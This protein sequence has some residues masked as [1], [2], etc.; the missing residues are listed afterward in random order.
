MLGDSTN[1]LNH[2]PSDVESRLYQVGN[3]M[4]SLQRNQQD[5]ALSATDKNHLTKLLEIW[6]DDPVPEQNSFMSSALFEDA[7]KQ[8][9]R[10]LAEAL[11]SIMGQIAV[12]R[13]LWDKIYAKMIRSTAINLPA[14]A[15]ALGLVKTSPEGTNEVAKA[16]RV[17]LTS[18]DDETASNAVRGIYRWLAATSDLESKVPQPPEDLVLEVGIAIASRRNAV[19][20]AAMQLAE[21]IYGNGQD[22]HK[23]TIQQLV[24][25]GLTYLA[26]ELR[27]DHPHDN[28][29]EIPRKRFYCAKLAVAMGKCGLGE[30]PAVV[31]WL[32]M[33]KEDPLP[34]VRQA[35]AENDPHQ[36][37]RNRPQI[38]PD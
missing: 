16:L 12:S 38:E 21:W 18:D 3:A 10:E 29:D 33:A 31:T 15:L 32:E 11:T 25:H 30:S 28:S 6:A 35:I 37:W 26:Q 23:E 36:S 22:S 7:T 2:D 17:G 14:F 13:H 8:S 4:Q 20:V 27:Y 19:I 34:E 5:F 9:I 24:D 1:G